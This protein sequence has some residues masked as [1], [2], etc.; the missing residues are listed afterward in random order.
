[1]SADQGAVNESGVIAAPT[2]ATLGSGAAASTSS[3]GTGWF[4]RF[5][6]LI[7]GLVAAATAPLKSGYAPVANIP[8]AGELQAK[9]GG[10]NLA[11]IGLGCAAWGVLWLLYGRIIHGLLPNLAIIAA[12]YMPRLISWRQRES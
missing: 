9:L 3:G 7:V 5:L 10:D 1:M 4:L 8:Q 12:A 2:G 11:Y 6:F